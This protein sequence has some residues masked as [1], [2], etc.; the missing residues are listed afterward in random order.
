MEVATIGLII[1]LT[2]FTRVINLLNIPIFT[3]EAIYIRWAQIGL[4]DPA[5]RFITL[6]D[7]KQP[8]LT[9]LMYPSLMIFKDP[10]FAGRFVSVFSGVLAA[11]GIYFL[12]RELFGKRV[13]LFSALIYIISPFFLLYDRL[14]LMDSLLSTIGIWSLY[15]TILLVSRV[16]LDVALLLGMTIGLGVLTKT[17]AFFYLY[18]LPLSM[19]LFDYKKKERLKRILKWI[20]LMSICII[21]A[22]VIYNSLRL[23]PWF[24][25]IEQKN[26][27]FIYTFAEFIKSPFT[28][29][30]PNLNGLLQFLF[31]YLTFPISLVLL[32]GILLGIVKLDRKIIYLFLWFLLPFLALSVFGKVLYPRFILF[33]ISPLLI[34][35][36]KTL[37]S[38]FDFTIK[39]NKI[40]MLIIPIILVYPL[41]QSYLLMT[42]PVEAATPQNDRNQ[43][44][45]DW[46]SGFGVREVIAYL[47]EESKKG[48]IVVG[49]EGTFGL[50]PAA[51]EI[52]LGLN[53]NM[54]IKGFWPVFEVPKELQRDALR[55]PTFL[56]FKEKQNIPSDWPLELVAKYRRGNGNTYLLFYR[57][58]PSFSM[59]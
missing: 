42:S 14:A 43:L 30:L 15:L 7:G 34:I 32:I 2:F 10:L 27:T 1:I 31:G 8:L 21:L 12:G 51:I 50:F 4:A 55:Y 37:S 9:W 23:S 38:L 41:Y 44:F 36:A 24:Y 22:Q 45:D 57:V 58:K 20:G 39:K 3:D 52:Y 29:F 59:K 11:I 16:R 26:Y 49:T 35:I 56:V 48:K 33:M 6:T 13:A 25:I 19:I 18:L 46:P 17:S 28:V 54:E 47:D 40:L 5:H 53:K